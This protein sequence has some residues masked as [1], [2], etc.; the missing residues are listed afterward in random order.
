MK[1]RWINLLLR[2][3]VVF[4]PLVMGFVVVLT[5]LFMLGDFRF[6]V[7]RRGM[8]ACVRGVVLVSRDTH[9]KPCAVLF[10]GNFFISYRNT[11]VAS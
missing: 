7:C 1:E 2:F 6:S 9:K 10:L 3:S 4:I 11:T 8:F 5:T